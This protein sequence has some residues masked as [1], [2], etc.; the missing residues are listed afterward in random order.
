MTPRLRALTWIAVLGLLA[1]GCKKEPSRWDQ[2]QEATR[3]QKATVTE[4]QAGGEFNKF[5]PKAED[6]F[7]LIYKQ[8]KTGFAE[9][10][11]KYDGREVALLSISDTV[12]NPDAKTKYAESAEK[13]G[14][15]PLAAIG[16]QGTGV[17]VADRYQVQVRSMDPEFIEVNRHEW[18]QQFDL[19][20]L[21]QLQ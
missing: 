21:S 20:G 17:L 19:A 4:S 10:S 7:D 15:Y 3:G 2:A 8:E 11:L 5:F 13:L 12:N 1:G 16:D 14:E 9:A 6:P 18:L